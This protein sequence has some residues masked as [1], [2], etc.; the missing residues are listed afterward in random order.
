MKILIVDDE[1]NILNQLR[2][3]AAHGC[4]EN[5]IT[6]EIEATDDPE[7]VLNSA[8]RYDVILLDIEMPRLSGLDLAARLNAARNGADKPY[9]IFVTNRDGLVFEALK[10]QPYSFVRKSHL[11]DLAPCLMRLKEKCG[12]EYL[13]V[14]SGRSTDRIAVSELIYLEKI[15]NYV[16]CHTISGTLRER[17]T[18]D[19]KAAQLTA[20]GFVRSHIGYLINM[21]YI[22][23]ILPQT[24][25]LTD[26]TQLPLSRKYVKSVRKQ[27]F[28]WM[29]NTQ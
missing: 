16:V 20:K 22:A 15:K 13:T 26:G 8:A 21:R 28:E 7:A 14:R 24:V 17:A 5:G 23:E 27:F 29:V 3:V 19:E 6:A 9:I 25:R 12:E 11:E 4:R 10:Q 18:M 1:Q 2:S